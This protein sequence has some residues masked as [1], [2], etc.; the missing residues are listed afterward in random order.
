VIPP[1]INP[2]GP[3][4]AGFDLEN[5]DAFLASDRVPESCMQLSELDGFLTAIA[6]GPAAVMPSEWLPVIWGQGEPVFESD[7]EL[8]SVVGT[9]FMR[10]EAILRDIEQEPDAYEPLLGETPDGRLLATDW[11]AGFMT[12][13]ALRKDAWRPLLQTEEGAEILAPS[14]LSWTT[15][16][17]SPWPRSSPTS[18]RRCARRLSS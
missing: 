15:R 12:G 1:R 11:A 10:H 16:T 18:W 5:L 17:A 7:A 9:I 14:S 3:D 6:I 8:Q 4:V 13:A 2:A